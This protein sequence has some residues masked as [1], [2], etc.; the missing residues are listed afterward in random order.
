MMPILAQDTVHVTSIGAQDG[1]TTVIVAFIFAGLIWPHLIKNRTQY[2]AGLVA[3]LVVILLH[4]LSLMIG[5]T[6]FQLFSGAMIGLLQIL[7]II[8]LF[9]SAGG[10][11]LKDLTNNLGDAYEVVRRGEEEKEVI[12]KRESQGGGPSGA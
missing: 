7:A 5:A 8:M 2:Y 4:S 9:L 6:A 3:V 10:M 12:I 1:V 11:T